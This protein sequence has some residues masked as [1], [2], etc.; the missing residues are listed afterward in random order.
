[1]SV[2]PSTKNEKDMP[3][4]TYFTDTSCKSVT[5]EENVSQVFSKNKNE[6]RRRIRPLQR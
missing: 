6:W 2:F 1:M 5:C 4:V 3:K